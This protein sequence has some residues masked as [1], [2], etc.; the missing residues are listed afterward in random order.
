MCYTFG[1]TFVF[2]GSLVR[3]PSCPKIHLLVWLP[4]LRKEKTI[5]DVCNSL[6]TRLIPVEVGQ[7]L[8]LSMRLF[9]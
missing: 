1:I 5:K 6:K 3:A 8:N 2:E 4:F 7:P 9:N